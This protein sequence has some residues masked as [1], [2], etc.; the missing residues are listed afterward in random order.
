L[1]LEPYR[2]EE[3]PPAL[4]WFR[5]LLMAMVCLDR[6]AA[7]NARIKLAYRGWKVWHPQLP[8]VVEAA[9][10]RDAT[11]DRGPMPRIWDIAPQMGMTAREL[12]RL[13][14][15]GNAPPPSHYD[16]VGPAWDRAVVDS[17]VKKEGV[18]P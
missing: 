15:G 9:R 13:V 7:E 14:Q 8:G 1:D 16:E 4:Q 17:W 11:N 6:T 2:E 5:E 10:R 18:Y 3:Y 12:A